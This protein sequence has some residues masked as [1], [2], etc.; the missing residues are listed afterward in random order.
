[1]ENIKT[2]K[3]TNIK[4]EFIEYNNNFEDVKKF[5]KENYNLVI[6]MV[7]GNIEVIGLE[8]NDMT[9]IIKSGDFVIRNIGECPLYNVVDR[10]LFNEIFI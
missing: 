1:M 3:N 9:S 10:E 7:T 8:L 5:I 4:Y 6:T 2:N